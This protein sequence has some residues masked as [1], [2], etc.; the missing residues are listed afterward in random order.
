M[1]IVAL[2]LLSPNVSPNLPK[3]VRNSTEFQKALF[4]HRL[5]NYINYYF[6]KVEVIKNAHVFVIIEFV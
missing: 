1:K 3:M 5:G 6:C 4:I 2:G